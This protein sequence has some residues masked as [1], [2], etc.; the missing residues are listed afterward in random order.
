MLVIITVHSSV[1]QRAEVTE[2]KMNSCRRT[3]TIKCSDKRE[4][5]FRYKECA[6]ENTPFFFFFTRGE[7]LGIA[8]SG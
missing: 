4:G 2:E 3:V 5:W 8:F 7:E 6:S 1:N